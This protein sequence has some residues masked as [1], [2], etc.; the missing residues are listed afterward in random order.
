MLHRR[1]RDSFD[2]GAE[3]ELIL[4]TSTGEERWFVDTGYWGGVPNFGP[5]SFGVEGLYAERLAEFAGAGDVI[6][7]VDPTGR[8]F[9][10][11]PSTG[12]TGNG[13]L[14]PYAATTP[15]AYA[16][17]LTMEGCTGSFAYLNLAFEGLSTM[18]D[19]TPWDY[20]SVLHKMWL[21]TPAGVSPPAALHLQ[22]EWLSR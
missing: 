11:G 22:A 1:K 13:A 15:N 3:G 10:Q 5:N 18:E 20:S 17:Q 2:H 8:F 21:S 19:W 4:T 6:I 16:V 14:T 9:F 12:C 7:N